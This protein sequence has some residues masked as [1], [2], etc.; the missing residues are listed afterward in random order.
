M[1]TL[2]AITNKPRDLCVMALQ[3]TQGNADMACSVLFEGLDMNQMQALIARSG[4]AGAGQGG[5][6]DAYDDYGAEDMGSANPMGAMPGMQP[7]MGGMPGGNPAMN[8][9]LAALFQSEQFSQLA[10]RMRE[11]PSFYTEF[12]QQT[13]Q[14][15]PAM[16]QAIMQN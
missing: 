4:G 9:Q 3:L 5:D 10:Q 7:P 16:Y 2:V 13:A 1:S 14:Q 11:N 12:V 15:N 6:Q 8:Q